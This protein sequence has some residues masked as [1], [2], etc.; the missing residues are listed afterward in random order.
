[1]TGRRPLR[2]TAEQ[3]LAY[4][5]GVTG[6]DEKLAPGS[7]AEAAWGGL[8]DSVPRGGVLSLH[9]RVA[10]TKP[11]SW[12]DPSLAQIWFR[13][14]ADYLVPRVDAG[15]FTLG[16][17]PRDPERARSLEALADEIHRLTGGRMTNS[18]ELPRH[19]GGRPLR[20]R[21][22]ALTGRIHIRWDATT[23][24]VIPVER[25]KIEPED[26]RRELAR[27]FLHWLGPR[28]VAELARWTGVE[29]RDAAATWR[30]IGP[31]LTPVRIEGRHEGRAIL[32]ADESSFDASVRAREAH[33]D[34]AP[35]SR[36]L[37]QDDP[38]TKL[39]HAWLLAAEAHRRL[40]L[41][42]VGSSPGYIPGVVLLDG[43]I[44]GA[45]QRQARVVTVRPFRTLDDE[46]REAIE[47]EALAVPVAGSAA[48]RVRWRT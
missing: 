43:Q 19:L 16:S 6:L 26:A 10:D 12:D 21:S 27:R 11:D 7:F 8:Q 41:P 24:W 32:A 47:A 37:P 30:A 15:I 29:P 2:L 1:M 38:Y 3:V 31:E 25:P 20:F 22:A 48:A 36:L 23:T 45:W 39:D 40:A 28:T 18:R 42:K 34:A 46:A 35:V 4:R 17:Y 9:A 13:G 33:R 5:R 14:G 44:V